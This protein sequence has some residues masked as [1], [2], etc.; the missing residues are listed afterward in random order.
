MNNETANELIVYLVRKTGWSLEYCRSIPINE[1]YTLVNEMR[2][3]E[4][5]DDYRLAAKFALIAII[6]I[7]LLAKGKMNV[8]DLIG[9]P[10]ERGA[11]YTGGKKDLWQMAKEAG[12]RIPLIS[13]HH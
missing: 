5:V 8:E 9:P 3:Q 13:P 2:Y 1:L 4:A 7:R 10:P 12:L 6:M 11:L